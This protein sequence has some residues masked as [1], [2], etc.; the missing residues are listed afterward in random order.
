MARIFLMSLTLTSLFSI[1]F[2]PFPPYIL[3]THLRQGA[4]NATS[5]TYLRHYATRQSERKKK[6]SL[7]I[8]REALRCAIVEI[9]REETQMRFLCKV[10]STWKFL[11][12]LATTA[13]AALRCPGVERDCRLTRNSL[14]LPI[15]SRTMSSPCGAPLKD[16]GIIPFSSTFDK[17]A[18]KFYSSKGASA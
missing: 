9:Q 11:R 16:K 17:G 2:I 14:T 7:R 15:S 1:P 4:E 5:I 12:F 6:T 3:H 8:S 10:S 13:F 18:K